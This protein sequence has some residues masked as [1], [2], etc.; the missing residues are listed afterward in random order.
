MDRTSIFKPSLEE[1]K[2]W[3]ARLVSQ[4][5]KMG[6]PDKSQMGEKW[7]RETSLKGGCNLTEIKVSNLVSER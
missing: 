7:V 4:G 6:L 3:P 1:V 5:S 2:N